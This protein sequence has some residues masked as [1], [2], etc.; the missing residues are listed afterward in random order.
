MAFSSE[1]LYFGGT[2]VK[3]CKITEDRH[4]SQIDERSFDRVDLLTGNLWYDMMRQIG[5]TLRNISSWENYAAR[6]DL[7]PARSCL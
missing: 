6:H 2:A 7:A 1:S 4:S 5:G 3:H